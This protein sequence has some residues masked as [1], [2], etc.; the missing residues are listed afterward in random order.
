MGCCSILCA[1]RL[2]AAQVQGVAVLGGIETGVTGAA[3]EELEIGLI[4]VAAP[5]NK[6]LL[7]S[8]CRAHHRKKG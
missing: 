7:A 5:L 1:W 2:G 3:C 6:E 8:N 4:W